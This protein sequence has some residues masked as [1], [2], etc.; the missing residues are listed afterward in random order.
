MRTASFSSKT[1]HADSYVS[2]A[3]SASSAVEDA[4]GDRLMREHHQE[5]A[6]DLSADARGCAVCL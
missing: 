3:V 2:K 4:A 5:L 6:A 1:T